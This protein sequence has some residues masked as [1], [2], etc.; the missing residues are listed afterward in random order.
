[1]SSESTYICERCKK[2]G[3]GSCVTIKFESQVGL[4]L[5]DEVDLCSDC[6]LLFVDWIKNSEPN[7]MGSVERAANPDPNK[8]GPVERVARRMNE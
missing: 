4:F 8:M 3:T 6:F 7:K 1:M 2:E 5:K